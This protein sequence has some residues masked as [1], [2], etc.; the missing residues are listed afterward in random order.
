[1]LGWDEVGEDE[2][3]DLFVTFLKTWESNKDRETYKQQRNDRKDRV[4][5]KRGGI[6]G[7]LL[8]VNTPKPL[9]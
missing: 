7:D 4:E 9:P 3:L 2:L 6:H 8:I 1:M 5:A